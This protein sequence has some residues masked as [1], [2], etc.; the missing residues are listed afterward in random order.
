MNSTLLFMAISGSCVPLFLIAFRLAFKRSIVFLI[1]SVF[2]FAI[3]LI[4]NLCF[5]VGSQG[6][7]HIAWALPVT[8]AA[9]TASLVIV[10]RRVARPIKAIE[11]AMGSMASGNLD[12]TAGEASAQDDLAKRANELGSLARSMATLRLS[13]VEFAGKV[14][15]TSSQVSSGANQLSSTAQGI[16][17]GANEQAASAEELSASVEELASSARQNASSTS[18]ADALSRRVAESARRSGG[19]VGTTVENMKEIAS[20]IS[21]IEEIARQT[22]LLALNAAIEA[23]RAGEA[24][25][26]F[27]VVASEVRKLAERSARAAGEINELS[28]RSVGVAG[29]AGRG[30]EELLPDIGRSA[31]LIREIAS[32]SVEQSS[33]ADQLAKGIGQVE[34]VIQQNASSSEELAA[35]SEELARQ[36]DRLLD[37]VGFFKIDGAG[38]AEA[39]LRG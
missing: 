27:A 17:Q 37:L 32:A 39:A 22:N 20:R 25:K 13:L 34:V 8:A 1:F 2:I 38:L 28:S 35:T 21:I 4:G 5:I 18:E 9:L 30:L 15:A 33:G 10:N 24:G 3:L 16:S 19:A 7:I 29:E 14:R 11:R 12:R 6:L 23:A 36:A 26:G 31:G